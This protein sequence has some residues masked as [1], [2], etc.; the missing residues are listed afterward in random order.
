MG[1]DR[2]KF[3]AT[4]VAIVQQQDKDVTT[5]VGK[6]KGSR[7]GY[8]KIKSG[9]NMFRIMPAH[10]DGGGES[11]IEPKS[12]V[13]LPMMVEEKDD[14]GQV[15]NG[16]DGKPLMKEGS[17]TVFN[18]RV[19]GNTEKDL[20]E[21]YF[22]IADEWAKKHK[23]DPTDSKKDQELRKKYTDKIWGNFKA[24]I[25]GIRYNHN[26]ALYAKDLLDNKQPIGLLEVKPSIKDGIN[27]IVNQEASNQ[28][29]GTEATDPFTPIEDGRALV[30]FY[31]EKAEKAAD[32]YTVSIDTATEPAEIQGRKVNIQKVYPLTDDDLEG[33]V[34]FPSLFKTFRNCFKR[35]DFELQYKGLEFFDI[36]NQMGIFNSPEFQAVVEEINA[37][38]P[39]DE[40]PDPNDLDEVIN[41]GAGAETVVEE[42]NTGDDEFTLMTRDELKQFN[43][44]NKVGMLIKPTTSD[45]AIR[46][47]M[48]E[49][50]LV[51]EQ[52]GSAVVEEPAVVA[53]AAPVVTE[54]PVVTST[55]AAVTGGKKYEDMTPTERKLY[56]MKQR[57]NKG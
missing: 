27:K 24:K 5:M 14:K 3:K 2:S 35:R 42:E 33:L 45:D 19:H 53:E 9:K 25:Q 17:K 21:E 32:Y 6:D 31:D 43:L 48:R 10:P 39:V 36:K 54:T 52:Q 7:A 56:D 20:V 30:I 23:F 1:I 55:P 41:E 51:N 12:T 22:R 49:W 18:S 57:Q 26:W 4:S 13:W 47:R 11:F 8:L 40:E 34:A 44:D 50:K 28:P 37:Y 16:A 38:Y 46:E 29:I 15:I